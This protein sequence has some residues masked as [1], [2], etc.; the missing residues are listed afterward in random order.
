MT[1]NEIKKAVKNH[2]DFCNKS[3]L[4]E[5]ADWLGDMLKACENLYNY[6][7]L[8]GY[9]VSDDMLKAANGFQ[10]RTGNY[11]TLHIYQTL[12]LRSIYIDD[13]KTAREFAE[14]ALLD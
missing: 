2:M 10:C 1:M 12:D 3:G 6:G 14:Y 9:E 7:G 8:R 11:E 4:E 13:K 5:L